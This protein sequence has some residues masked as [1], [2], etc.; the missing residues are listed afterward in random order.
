MKGLGFHTMIGHFP[1]CWN[2]IYSRLPHEMAASSMVWIHC[3]LARLHV[4][5]ASSHTSWRVNMTGLAR[6]EVCVQ[7]TRVKEKHD[8]QISAS[9]DCDQHVIA[10]WEV[11]AGAM[12]RWAC[13]TSHQQTPPADTSHPTE[14]ENVTG[15]FFLNNRWSWLSLLSLFT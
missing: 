6:L 4:P 12:S 15:R 7:L 14:P 13:S 5:H 3:A 10:T 8:V 11:T 2:L 1:P 9:F